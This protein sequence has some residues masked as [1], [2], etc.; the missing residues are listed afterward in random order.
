M[1]RVVGTPSSGT[2][3]HR[4]QRGVEAAVGQ[5]GGAIPRT[6]LR[7]STSALLAS[8][9]ASAIS[10]LA[11]GQIGVELGL[12]QAD[13]HGQRHQPR[14]HA[15]VQI[16]L[17]AVSFGLR[18]GHR[19]LTG[20]GERTDLVLQCSGRRRRQQPP[21]DGGVER[22]RE[23]QNRDGRGDRAP[24]PAAKATGGDKKDNPASASLCPIAIAAAGPRNAK[25]RRAPRQPVTR[26][27]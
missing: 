15:V 25:T 1:L 17:D 11:V 8:S 20:I 19:A 27:S 12:R 7:S 26:M 23:H 24:R 4:R 22:R 9:C 16:A 10:F 6:T 3:D 2:L 18:R 13:R 21:V 14:L 5:D